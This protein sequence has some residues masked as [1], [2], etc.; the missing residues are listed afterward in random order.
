MTIEIKTIIPIELMAASFAVNYRGF[1]PPLHPFQL[2]NVQQA[3]K[4]FAESNEYNPVNMAPSEELGVI[5]YCFM[6]GEE[7]P[8]NLRWLWG[9][10]NIL[11]NQLSALV[12]INPLNK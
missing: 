7:I 2:Q 11:L 12:S 1:D 4:N 5:A 6:T 9:K 10:D 3:I 8:R